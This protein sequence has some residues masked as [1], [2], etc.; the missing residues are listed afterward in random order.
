MPRKRYLAR[1][2]L[3]SIVSYVV[4]CAERRAWGR[5]DGQWQEY[6]KEGT[7]STRSTTT[8]R[9]R[10]KE[11]TRKAQGGKEGALCTEAAWHN[12]YVLAA[13]LSLG[14]RLKKE[15]TGPAC[16]HARSSFLS[17]THPFP[18]LHVSYSVHGT[19]TR[20]MYTGY[21]ILRTHRRSQQTRMWRG[22]GALLCA[23]VGRYRGTKHCP[24]RLLGSRSASSPITAVSGDGHSL[25]TASY[26]YILL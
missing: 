20:T 3:S 4:L 16:F 22:G 14:R 26:A 6:R 17:R 13:G 8:H 10:H 25:P 21:P 15:R 12:S 23:L 7:R 1:A 2:I 24:L 18:L 5:C 19:C 9:R 11:G